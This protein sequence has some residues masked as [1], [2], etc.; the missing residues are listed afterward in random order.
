M[1]YEIYYYFWKK[2]I[3]FISRLGLLYKSARLI[4]LSGVVFSYNICL[5]FFAI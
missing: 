1:I 5:L 2:I 4:A 3:E